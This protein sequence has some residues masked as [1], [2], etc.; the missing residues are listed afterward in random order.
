LDVFA[1]L[2]LPHCLENLAPGQPGKVQVE[3]DQVGTPVRL[4]VEIRD[5]VGRCAAVADNRQ[6]PVDAMLLQRLADQPDIALVILDQKNRG[7]P[8]WRRSRLLRPR[9]GL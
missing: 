8:R 9:P 4:A 2:A 5:E 3:N 7:Q 1:L 6:F